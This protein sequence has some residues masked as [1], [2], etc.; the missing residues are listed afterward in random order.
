MGIVYKALRLGAIG[1]I[2]SMLVLL[3]GSQAFANSPP[4]SQLGQALPTPNVTAMRLV[5]LV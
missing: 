1:T 5:R 3:A 4:G 2:A